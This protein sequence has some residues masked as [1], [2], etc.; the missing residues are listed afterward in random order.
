MTDKIKVVFAGANGFATGVIDCPSDQGKSTPLFVIIVDDNSGSMEGHRQLYCCLK[1]QSIVNACQNAGV[2]YQYATFGWN[3]TQHGAATAEKVQQVLNSSEGTLLVKLSEAACEATNILLSDLGTNVVFQVI[4]VL[5][6]DGESLD[7]AQAGKEFNEFYQNLQKKFPNMQIAR[8][9]VLGIGADHDQKVLAAMSVGESSYY[10]YPENGL[11]SMVTDTE[12]KINTE[13][14]GSRRTVEIIITGNDTK[15]RTITATIDN[16]QLH[17]S[18]I[19]IQQN[20]HS[21]ILPDGRTF[22]L[23]H[24]QLPECSQEYYTTEIRVIQDDALQLASRIKQIASTQHDETI[25]NELKQQVE[26]L[27]A[28][29]DDIPEVSRQGE[30]REELTSLLID[31]NGEEWRKRAYAIVREQIKEA[32]GATIDRKSA[33]KA[34]IDLCQ[35]GLRCLAIGNKLATD[36][37]R[38]YM[39]LLGSGG[40]DHW[41]AKKREKLIGRALEQANPDS[42]IQADENASAIISQHEQ[43]IITDDAMCW[44]TMMTGQELAQMGDVLCIV[45]YVPRGAR[46]L[47]LCSVS[48][49]KVLHQAILKKKVILCPQPM[50]FLTMRQLLLSGKEIA[51]GPH[52]A[53]INTCV[54]L[55][56]TP[57]SK[58]SKHLARC[59]SAIQCSQL[60][61]SRWVYTV[62]T[63][64]YRNGMMSVLASLIR[65][66]SSEAQC[67]LLQNAIQG[68]CN[69]FSKDEKYMT[70]VINRAKQFEN[71]ASTSGE[72]PTILVALIDQMVLRAKEPN[73][74]PPGK[75]FWRATFMRLLRDR[76]S[77][78]FTTHPAANDP[79][80]DMK[81]KQREI[82]A[83]TFMEIL[84]QGLPRNTEHEKEEQTQLRSDLENLLK[85][86][87][88]V[89][90]V[91]YTHPQDDE[92]KRP[93][94]EQDS[95]KL[96]A[97]QEE[98][99]LEEAKQTD[100]LK[101]ESQQFSLRSSADL[102]IQ[103]LQV[104]PRRGAPNTLVTDEEIRQDLD[105]VRKA[106]ITMIMK[107]L[108]NEIITLVHAA[109]HYDY[110]CDVIRS[111]N[112]CM[113]DLLDKDDDQWVLSQLVTALELRANSRF[114]SDYEL[115]RVNDP[116][117]M[118]NKESIEVLLQVNRQF[119]EKQVRNWEQVE[120]HRKSL[121]RAKYRR[122]YLQHPLN[123]S[124]L[125]LRISDIAH[126]E[127]IN[128]WMFENRGFHVIM[129]VAP[130]SD[131]TSM[132]KN[133][134]LS[135]GSPFFMKQ[136]KVYEVINVIYGGG[137]DRDDSQWISDLHTNA[138]GF[139]NGA[140]QKS[141]EDQYTLFERQLLDFV[142]SPSKCSTARTVNLWCSFMIDRT[143]LDDN[144][145]QVKARLCEH[146]PTRVH[147][148]VRQCVGDLLEWHQRPGDYLER[149]FNTPRETLELQAF[150]QYVSA[151]SN[152]EV[153]LATEAFY[154][155][156]EF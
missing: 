2:K 28:R 66:G 107:S 86:V 74:K 3:A 49:S 85:Y 46:N 149:Y 102:L 58:L 57:H 68:F 47:P 14:K 96:I 29:L 91:L 135:P 61:T 42:I 48:S 87:T 134:Y 13:I 73:M 155:P 113:S 92:M 81:R 131:Y 33:A 98:Q 24:E 140:V 123:L 148:F 111:E 121:L 153:Q 59:Y 11:N 138:I 130:N 62:G 4:Y 22:Q 19:R 122:M 52:G 37:E 50:S 106:I 9:F 32:K 12:Q 54:C 154:M 23:Q 25:L 40:F 83:V 141:T 89:P 45:G 10:N 104:C 103:L 116:T 69:T 152:E 90:D 53:P 35:R 75:E 110:Q 34:V 64:E 17:L 41:T 77:D 101:Q 71:G 1:S 7:G 120:A 156:L 80:A 43:E 55:V 133:T 76:L 117:G 67:K 15:Q 79:Q 8:T 44:V 94:Q 132:A 97:Y 38:D 39:E 18:N 36:I 51:R 27:L 125:P 5:N 137:L 100:E 16:E 99:P 63:A 129:T 60:M 20:E 31:Q 115:C 65:E 109:D 82:D 151:V 147:E 139:F 84:V 88:Q 118:L 127:R 114:R 112:R 136:A 78:L 93:M 70:D 142:K 145:E 126:C 108:K 105:D 72:V 143:E 144:V 21:F 124:F 6:T 95:F 146:A 56:P 119:R 128:Q 150:L 26:Q 30:L